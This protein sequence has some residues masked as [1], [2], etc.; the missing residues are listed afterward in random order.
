MEKRAQSEDRIIHPV[1]QEPLLYIDLVTE[2]TIDEIVVDALQD[3]SIS[4]QILTARLKNYAESIRA[5]L[6]TGRGRH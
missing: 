1:K 3:K 6:Q 4:A 2:G 5:K